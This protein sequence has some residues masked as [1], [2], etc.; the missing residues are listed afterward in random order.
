MAVRNMHKVGV[1]FITPC[2][3]CYNLATIMKRFEMSSSAINGKMQS[4]HWK[5]VQGDPADLLRKTYM[6]P[7]GFLPGQLKG[8]SV[9]IAEVPAE[10]PPPVYGPPLSG[11]P[12]PESSA[13]AEGTSNGGFLWFESSEPDDPFASQWNDHVF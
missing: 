13:Q 8:W 6:L 12:P 10:I 1:K 5:S 4:A 9:R 3:L 7:L 2:C 11:R